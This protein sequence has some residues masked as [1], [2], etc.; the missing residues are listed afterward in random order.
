ML[1]ALLK[2]AGSSSPADSPDASEP[3]E[4]D[5]IDAM[6]AKALIQHVMDGT[7]A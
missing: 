6:D 5:L 2:L 4:D 3:D 1:E 7:G